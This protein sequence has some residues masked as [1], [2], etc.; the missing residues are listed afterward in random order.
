MHAWGLKGLVWLELVRRVGRA[1]GGEVG[2]FAS[3]D[4][5]TNEVRSRDFILS[6]SE[7]IQGF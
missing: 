3:G 6:E 5:E 2:W 1:A 7:A 4:S